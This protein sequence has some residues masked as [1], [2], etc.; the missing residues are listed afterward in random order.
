MALQWYRL[1]PATGRLVWKES[2]KR[3]G[4]GW[5]A[6]DVPLFDSNLIPT[7]EPGPGETF[8]VEGTWTIQEDGAW[9]IQEDPP[10]YLQE[11]A[12]RRDPP[13]AQGLFQQIPAGKL[14]AFEYRKAHP[15][16]YRPPLQ[17]VPRA[18][19]SGPE[20]P[21]EEQQEPSP[22]YHR[23]LREMIR[24]GY[25]ETAAM[26]DEVAPLPPVSLVPRPEDPGHSPRV[27]AWWRT[28][29]RLSSVRR[30]RP[31]LPWRSG[32]RV[33]GHRKQGWT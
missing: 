19:T 32:P 1:D 5:E 8:Q 18:W 31:A 3:P 28:V 9:T 4:P 20:W 30:G 17:L 16:E 2:K 33:A 13:A 27:R 15:T 7:P 25:P 29:H 12:V 22:E 14:P 23:E 26:L 10:V 24:R 21:T 11:E 6:S